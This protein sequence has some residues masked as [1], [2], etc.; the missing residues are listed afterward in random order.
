MTVGKTSK[1]ISSRGFYLHNKSIFSLYLSVLFRVCSPVTTDFFFFFAAFALL[2]ISGALCQHAARPH[3]NQGQLCG[4]GSH[5]GHQG[6]LPQVP[7]QVSSNK[8]MSVDVCIFFVNTHHFYN[9]YE[10]LHAL[11]LAFEQEYLLGLVHIHASQY[12]VLV[13]FYFAEWS[14]WDRKKSYQVC[15]SPK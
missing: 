3:P 1:Q 7:Q 10:I 4:A 6:Y 15:V 12:Y 14:L 8:E 13:V 11:Y 2:A 9:V 5:C